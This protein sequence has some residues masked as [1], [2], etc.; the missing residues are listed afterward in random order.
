M[1]VEVKREPNESVNAM[2]RRFSRKVQLSGI[3]LEARKARFYEKKKN[4]E[5]KRAEALYKLRKKKEM[6]RKEKMGIL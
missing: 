2:L 1:T 5:K 4:R 3:L 6:E